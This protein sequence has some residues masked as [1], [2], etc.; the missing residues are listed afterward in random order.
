[1]GR[2][3]AVLPGSTSH[4]FILV[5]GAYNVRRFGGYKSSIYPNATTREGLIYRSGNLSG[6]TRTGWEIVQ[7]LGVS[8]IID[9]TN[10]K[11]VETFTGAARTYANP[12]GIKTVHLPFKNG[13]FSIKRQVDKYK[14]YR[15]TTPEVRN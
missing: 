3:T 10:P 8:T 14:I 6:V 13:E 4:P 11:E 12:S 5:P 7:K 2:E 1:M 15:D 9:L